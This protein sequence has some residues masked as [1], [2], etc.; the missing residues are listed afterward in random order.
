[1]RKIKRET[2]P[3]EEYKA[4]TDFPQY[5]LQTKTSAK[6]RHVGTTH[7]Q[8]YQSGGLKIRVHPSTHTLSPANLTDEQGKEADGTAPAISIVAR[9]NV[10]LEGTGGEETDTG[11]ATPLENLGRMMAVACCKYGP[12]LVCKPQ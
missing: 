8:I 11:R 3:T 6:K 4:P 7:N 12:M 2:L 1:M 10:Q 5:P 9:S